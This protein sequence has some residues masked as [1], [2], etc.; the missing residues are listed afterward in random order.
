MNQETVMAWVVILT[1]LLGFSSCAL[2]L[3]QLNQQVI[4]KEAKFPPLPVMIILDLVFLA[5]AI[6]VGISLYRCILN[7]FK[8]GDPHRN[9]L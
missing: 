6:L 8:E 7:I 3:F 5:L 2:A 9:S 1:C 4:K